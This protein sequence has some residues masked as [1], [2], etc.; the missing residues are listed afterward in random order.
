[1]AVP[2][3]PLPW[4]QKGFDQCGSTLEGG[5]QDW[6]AWAEVLHPVWTAELDSAGSFLIPR[7]QQFFEACQVDLSIILPLEGKPTGLVGWS[8]YCKL[9]KVTEVQLSL[10]RKIVYE[11]PQK[12]E[13]N[14]L[15]QTGLFKLNELGSGV[16]KS[17]EKVKAWDGWKILEMGENV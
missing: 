1:M 16:Y 5:G 8:L 3:P 6:E 4:L 10:L 15:V 14:R 2:S 9:S 12:L 17:P 13:R 11:N 7:M